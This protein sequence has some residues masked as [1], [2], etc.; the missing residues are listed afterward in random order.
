M[1]KAIEEGH[2]ELSPNGQG[3]PL[4]GVANPDK[5]FDLVASEKEVNG[6]PRISNRLLTIEPGQRKKKGRV[7]MCIQEVSYAKRS[8]I[9]RKNSMELEKKADEGTRISRSC[10]GG[11]SRLCYSNIISLNPN[12]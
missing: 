7:E 8:R 5:R 3:S 9:K 10:V 12:G 1:E 11:I 4:A 6:F 2:R